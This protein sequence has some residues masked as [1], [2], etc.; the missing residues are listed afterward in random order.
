[1]AKP[2][3][4]HIARWCNARVYKQ[5]VAQAGAGWHVRLMIHTTPH[6]D[7]LALASDMG[8][9]VQ[10]TQGPVRERY[11]AVVVH[12]TIG[13]SGDAELFAMV[14]EGTQ[15]WL[16]WDCHDYVDS[17]ASAGYD[18]VV[19]T[20]R[21]MA[22][23]SWLCPSHVVYSK[24]A[25]VMWPE[26]SERCVNACV[27]Q[28]TLDRSVMWGDYS[29]LDVG[30]PLFV[31]PSGDDVS[32]FEHMHLMRRVSYLDMLR[33]L[34]MYECGYAGASQPGVVLD[35]VVT[36]KYWEYIAAGIP[37]MLGGECAEMSVLSAMYGLGVAHG[38]REQIRKHIADIKHEL[39]MEREL[40]N[41]R[42][43]YG[44]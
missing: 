31:Y 16:V 18:S 29:G 4:L 17:S 44:L 30:M 1:M 6:V 36:N 21:G 32:G 3:I 5:V 27:F 12:T 38:S 25:G 10:W 39:C 26:W 7:L 28:G 11:D 15:R 23:E 37:V 19:C 13:N 35:R 40:D 43:A 22:G 20:C 8:L 42:A 9:L 24:V 34:S 2:S 14:H 33:R 41:M